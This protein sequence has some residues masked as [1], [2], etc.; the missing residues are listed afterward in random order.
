MLVASTSNTSFFFKNDKKAV[1]KSGGTR[2]RTVNQA[3]MS[4]LL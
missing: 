3:V 1:G 2:I 4:R